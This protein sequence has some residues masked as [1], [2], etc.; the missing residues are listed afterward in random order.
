MDSFAKDRLPPKELWPR[1]HFDMP[2]LRYPERLNCATVLLDDAIPEGHGERS[3]LL[4]DA[5]PITYAELLG[6]ANRIASVLKEAGVV[7][8]NRVLLRMASYAMR[9]DS[10]L[11]VSRAVD[12]SNTA[13]IIKSF[14]IAA[15]SPGDSNAV[16]EVTSLFTTDVSELNAR[17]LGMRVRRFDPARSFIE[18]ARSFPHN[19]EVSALHTFEVDSIP[20][21]P[22]GS[23]VR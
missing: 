14:D 6:R 22:G 10:T 18:R 8:G 5:G 15:W 2:E 21:A 12:L 4:T 13:P 3:A 23:P 1:L 17:Q 9:A 19:V 7:P 16:I 20:A 11:P